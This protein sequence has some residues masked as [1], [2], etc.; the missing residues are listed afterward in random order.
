MA[1]DPGEDPN[2]ELERDMREE[3]VAAVQEAGPRFTH[4]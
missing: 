2:R 4:K 3:L 1:W